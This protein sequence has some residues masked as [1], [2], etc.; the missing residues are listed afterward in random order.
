MDINFPPQTLSTF[1]TPTLAETWSRIT[2]S[3]GSIAA[4]QYADL[5]DAGA[6]VRGM[7]L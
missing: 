2:T 7:T 6:A 1:T 5:I 3:A 4:Q